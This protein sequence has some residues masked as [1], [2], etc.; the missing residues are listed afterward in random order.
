MQLDFGTSQQTAAEIESELA[1]LGCGFAPKRS[2]SGLSGNSRST[3]FGTN[4]RCRLVLK[5]SAYWAL[6]GHRSVYRQTDAI[7][8]TPRGR[9]LSVRE[10][11]T[12]INVDWAGSWQ[13]ARPGNWLGRSPA[14]AALGC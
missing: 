8:R 1:F 11:L 13:A 10:G 7:D 6:S 4:A 5:L 3:G 12:R 9:E 2:G 14:K